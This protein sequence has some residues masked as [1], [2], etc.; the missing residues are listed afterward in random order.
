MS[1]GAI[2]TDYAHKF[3]SGR[4]SDIEPMLDESID[5]WVQGSGSFGKG[6]ILGVMRTVMAKVDHASTEI[7]ELLESGDR[8]VALMRTT[9]LLKSGA[10]VVDE[11]CLFG[12]V[13]DGR[14][15]R[16]REY[17]DQAIMSHFL[18]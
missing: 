11:L 13:A 18:D 14:I 12:Q 15:V 10:R 17:L 16:G 3:A 2:I 5:Y 9:F 7:L 8:A 1:P 6:E 4:I